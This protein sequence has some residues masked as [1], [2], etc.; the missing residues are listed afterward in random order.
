MLRKAWDQGLK[1]VLSA[2]LVMGLVPTSA[3]AEALDDPLDAPDDLAVVEVVE[4]SAEEEPEQAEPEQQVEQAAEPEEA[5]PQEQ[6]AAPAEP[7]PAEPAPE[8]SAPAL[9]AQSD[10][11]DSG[12]Y[13]TLTWTLT[14]EG[15]LTISG[16]GDMPDGYWGTQDGW[17]ADNNRELITSVIIEGGVTNIGAYAFNACHD[18]AFVQIP[19]TVTT[20]KQNAFSDCYALE[21]IVI[22]EGVTTIEGDAF[23]C[24]GSLKSISLPASLESIDLSNAFWGC[25]L[26]N[27]TTA[28]GCIYQADAYGALYRG[29]KL[30]Y[31]PEGAPIEHYEIKEGTTEIPLIMS[32]TLKTLVIPA[33]LTDFGSHYLMAPALESFEV[34]E[35]NPVFFT[36]EYGVLYA[37]GSYGVELVA[38][39][40]G[41]TRESYT[42]L[43]GTVALQASAFSMYGATSYDSS[44][45][46]AAHCLRE[47]ILPESL[48]TIEQ[49]CFLDCLVLETIRIPAACEN[50]WTDFRGCV[51]LT[52]FE[53]DPANQHF[54][55]DEYG[56]LYSTD[57]TLLRFP[58][59][60]SLT[61]YAVRPDTKVIASSSFAY[62]EWDYGHAMPD[63]SGEADYAYDPVPLTHL[64]IPSSV[65]EVGWGAFDG[66]YISHLT[67]LSDAVSLEDPIG[68]YMPG[69]PTVRCHAGSTAEAWANS[70]G[71]AVETI[72]ADDF[73]ITIVDEQDSY[74]QTDEPIT[75]AVTVSRDGAQLSA[76]DYDVAYGDNV[77]G[78][79][80]T[81]LVTGKGEYAGL[82]SEKTFQIVGEGPSTDPTTDPTIGLSIVVKTPHFEENEGIVFGVPGETL[83]I[84]VEVQ[85]EEGNPVDNATFAWHVSDDGLNAQGTDT[86]ALTVT[87][88]DYEGGFDVDVDVY[89]GSAYLGNRAIDL[90]SSEG[91]FEVTARP[92][93]DGVVGNPISLGDQNVALDTSTT[94]FCSL[95][96][97]INA[98]DNNTTVP[99]WSVT[100]TGPDGSILTGDPTIS[101]ASNSC[102]A[103]GGEVTGERCP[104]PVLTFFRGGT[105]TLQF[106][107]NHS[108]A[109][110]KS[111][112]Y[113][114]K[115]TSPVAKS[116]TWGNLAWSI[117]DSGVLTISG[118]GPMDELSLGQNEAWL[119]RELS[120]LITSVVI[121]PGVTSIS[122]CA[123][124]YCRDIAR[125]QIP[126]GVT[127]IGH[128]AFSGCAKLTEIALPA[129]L[130]SL[131]G[132]AFSGCVSLERFTVAAGNT[133]F[134][135]DDAGA[136]F[137]TATD[138]LV[139]FPVGSSV[140]E[141]QV[142]AG[143]RFVDYGAFACDG[144]Q[145]LHPSAGSS[146]GERPALTAVVFPESLDTLVFGAFDNAYI[147]NLTFE[148]ADTTF[149]PDQ[150]PEAPGMPVTPTVHCYEGSTA[151]TWAQENGFTVDTSLGTIQTIA[152][153]NKTVMMG[154]T[155]S[156][157]ATA[158]GGGELSY[159]SSDPTVAEVS[160]AGVVT[161]VKPGTVQI[162][163]TAARTPGF[164]KATK[165]VTVTVTK[166]TQ[167]ITAANKSV[168]MGKTV[169]LGA[170]ASGGGKLTYKS[171]STAVAK[172]SAAGVVTPVKVGKA[173]ITITAAAT[174]THAQATKTVT[175]T[176]TKGTQVISAAAK[177]VKTGKT[178][179]LGAK[180][181]A[182]N[183]KLTYKSSNTTIATVNANGVVTGKNVGTATITI[184]AAGTADWNKATKTVSVK[185]TAQSGVWKGSGSKWWYQWADGGYPKSQFLTISGKTYYFDASGYCVYGWKQIS[186]KYY[187]F[188]GSG[189]MAKS[190]WVGSYY[191]Q[192]DGT[193]ATNK[194]IGKYHVGANGKWDKTR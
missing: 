184:T 83:T 154:K 116:G 159:E 117:S 161:A 189:A 55:A 10:P 31:F 77:Y 44:A 183:G 112:T 151:E 29:E 37:N 157:D 59:G 119:H 118:E 153:L 21:E 32:D 67:V 100:V 163:I 130:T 20:I 114:V 136:L 82:A 89:I 58:V 49:N 121:E 12:T 102:V 103:Y 18:L 107:F 182:G 106:A 168:A 22:P 34:A 122:P 30:E 76:E 175:V 150:R 66:A 13:G 72:E 180:R 15:V 7:A 149:M 139:R 113:T 50:L 17:L 73:A 78:P 26:S 140:Q 92:F 63:T 80:A 24:C 166:L 108:D 70:V 164:A 56:V 105:Y 43:D 51:H 14:D 53:V 81:I 74:D 27:I 147:Q 69:E 48:K 179:S 127:S 160:A 47:V 96:G 135:T 11:V 91:S 137:S 79:T 193:M 177:T 143:T 141:Y 187:Y 134:H 45:Q 162:T 142:P 94:Y 2:S 85:D 194:W 38:Y 138:M 98:W 101:H 5:E 111:I 33:S 181:T 125:V 144:W 172:V 126:E 52:A 97:L 148:G 176:V 167:T 28:E 57:G 110:V 46:E 190:K 173:T 3:L 60:S 152:A 65:T 64:V 109:Q 6:P 165:T 192:A 104:T 93:K 169:S 124:W 170:K 86:S 185:V 39:P 68:N 155:V 88:P 8:A 61:S 42:V 188:E 90:R 95:N 9:T 146:D 16:E 25:P 99:F 156:L 128:N 1:I 132:S 84:P 171:S 133:A 115:V 54:F 75:P 19:S 174:G 120:P 123:F 23:Y 41:A 40:Q 35:G 178:V 131:G 158:S 87:L 129:S 4:E 71:F 186:G 36:D 62:D 145:E 191:L